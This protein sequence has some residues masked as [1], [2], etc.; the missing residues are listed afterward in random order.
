MALKTDRYEAVTD[1][2]YVMD[3]TA[4]RG[5]MACQQTAGS[6]AAM[7]QA[8][9]VARYIAASPSCNMPLGIL[10][11]DVVN[12]DLTRQHLNFHKDEVQLGS[13]VTLLKQGWVVTN[14]IHPQVTITAG[15]RIYVGTSGYLTN[16]IVDSVTHPYSVGRFDGTVDSDGYCKVWVNLP[17]ATW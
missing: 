6:G 11:N 4:Q 14:W 1:I 2:S 9:N 12:L 15:E 16:A 8:V 13:K 7:D 5:G 10:L 17:V 3:Q